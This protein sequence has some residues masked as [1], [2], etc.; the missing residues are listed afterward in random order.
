L[1]FP[2]DIHEKYIRNVVSQK[3][4][5]QGELTAVKDGSKGMGSY[6]WPLYNYGVDNT[7]YDVRHTQ[8]ICKAFFLFFPPLSAIEVTPVYL[9]PLSKPKPRPASGAVV[10]VHF[11]SN[12][13]ELQERSEALTG[14]FLFF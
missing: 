5:L 3:H 11:N 2:L 9:N 14:A 10:L 13:Y 1:Q 4:H 6:P 8:V 7:E 12:A